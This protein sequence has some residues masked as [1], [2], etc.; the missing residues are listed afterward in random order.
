MGCDI[1]Y[2]K[3]LVSWDVTMKNC[4]FMGFDDK[5]RVI[6]FDKSHQNHADS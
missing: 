3:L 2:L 5:K 1:K 4:D 6:S